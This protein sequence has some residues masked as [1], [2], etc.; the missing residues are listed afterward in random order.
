MCDA[1][2][3]SRA[4][5]YQTQCLSGTSARSSRMVAMLALGSAGERWI[6]HE[7]RR[8]GG[9]GELIIVNHHRC[10]TNSPFR[11]RCSS[12]HTYLRALFSDGQP[13]LVALSGALTWNAYSR[14]TW[15][16]RAL[17]LLAD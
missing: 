11:Y 9:M 1:I 10:N 17:R 4:P 2:V 7:G 12:A 13:K 15:P 5:T 8:R 14:E 3:A 16:Y 6:T